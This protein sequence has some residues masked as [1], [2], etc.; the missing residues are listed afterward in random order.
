MENQLSNLQQQY[1]LSSKKFW[2]KVITK[3]PVFLFLFVFFLMISFFVSTRVAVYSF[4]L[5]IG[6]L[7]L[8]IIC[9]SLYA[10]YVTVYI[11]R[12]YYAGGDDFITIKKGVFAPAEIHVQY[13][14]I[15]DVYVDQDI[16]DRI[17]GLYDVHIA[18]ATMASSI[19]AHID[20]VDGVAAEGLKNFFLN[21]IKNYG[22]QNNNVP[23]SPVVN[24]SSTP[25][26]LNVSE[27]ISNETYPLSSGWILQKIVSSIWSA[28]FLVAIFSSMLFLPGKNST[29]S[30][31][32]QLGFS[33]LGILPFAVGLILFLVVIYVIYYLIWKKTYTFQ[34]LPQ[35]IFVRQGVIS[36]QEKNLPYNTIQDVSVKQ[37]II[38]RLLGISSV[39]IQNAA[40]SSPVQAGRGR[41]I[42]VFSGVIIPGQS[43]E[44]ANKI[45]DVVKSTILNRNSN[46]TGL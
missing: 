34:F 3:I 10:T 41:V 15:Q 35:F 39:Y 16:L 19:E 31:S 22:N 13:Q 23:V 25:I 30:I 38:E 21:K 1:P 44:R 33:F 9:F 27:V 43:L 18:S 26:T 11:K 46:S 17:M 36:R 6:S 29:T 24:Q 14:K 2:K 5:Y 12:Y 45:A 42:S 7:L 40:Q 4:F 32:D 37:G 28:I 8:S 20:G